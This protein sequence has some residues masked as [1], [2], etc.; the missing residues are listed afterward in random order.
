MGYG[1][2]LDLWLGEVQGEMQSFGVVGLVE[3]MAGDREEVMPTFE[4]N[5]LLQ[6]YRL[7]MNLRILKAF[8]KSGNRR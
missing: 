8:P 2:G 4:V 5:S 7:S 6:T 3:R 1:E